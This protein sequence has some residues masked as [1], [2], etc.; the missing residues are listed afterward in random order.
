MHVC[1][2]D[3]FIEHQLAGSLNRVQRKDTSLFRS[4]KLHKVQMMSGYMPNVLTKAKTC[5]YSIYFWLR[6]YWSVWTC[7]VK[8]TTVTKKDRK[9]IV[10][11]PRKVT[12]P[13]DTQLKTHFHI[14]KSNQTLL[15][16]WTMC[17]YFKR[18][19]RALIPTYTHILCAD[20]YWGSLKRRLRNTWG[21]L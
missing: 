6:L 16:M 11:F 15:F 7:R 9:S 2:R 13:R 10:C 12:T 14:M 20:S 19:K 17:L 1:S 5:Q 3:V 18:K 21:H 8:V 4:S